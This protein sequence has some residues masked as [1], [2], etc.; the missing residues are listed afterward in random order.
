MNPVWHEIFEAVRSET[1]VNFSGAVPRSVGGGCINASYVVKS[2]RPEE[3]IFVKL[4]DAS[5]IGMF[6]SEFLALEEIAA[7]RTIRV[8]KPIASGSNHS[9]AWIAME[10]IELVS[11]SDE[12]SQAEMGRRLAMMHRYQSPEGKFGWHRE[13]VIGE[14]PQQN[15]WT[16]S[17]AEFFAQHRLAFQF[18]LAEKRLGKEMKGATKLIARVPDLLGDHDPEPSLLHGDLW[19]GNAAFDASSGDPVL[20]DPATYYGDR[21]TDL[22]FTEFFGGFGPTFYAAYEEEFPP[23][24][25]A[26]DRASLYNL[27]HVLNHFHLFGGGYGSQARGIVQQLLARKIE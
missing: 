7:T 16:D 9:Q 2:G 4:N 5:K 21:E 3:S 13:N 14:T 27:Y 24:P 1:G 19:G 26:A 23:A 22:A 15:P 20:F 17:W 18:R 10:S 11:R 12:A 8:P 25:G 6:E